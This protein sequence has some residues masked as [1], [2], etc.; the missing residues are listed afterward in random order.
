MNSIQI[1]AWHDIGQRDNYEDACAASTVSFPLVAGNKQVTEIVA[2]DGAGFPGNGKTASNTGSD[3]LSQSILASFAAAGSA[4][5]RHVFA[6]DNILGIL[7]SALNH[8]NEDVLHR[9]VA[10]PRLKGMATTAVCAII[11]DGVLYVGWVGDTSC[12]VCNCSR[13]RKVTH[14]HSEVQRLIDA[15]LINEKEAKYHPLRHTINRF[16]GQPA[17]FSPETT[18]CSL[19]DGDVVLL[20]T[21]GLTDVLADEQIADHIC[22]YREGRYDFRELPK[23][24]VQH[25]L[26]AGTTDNV[27]VL[28]CEYHADSTPFDRTLTGAYPAAAAEAIR[29]FHKELINV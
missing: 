4:N 23:R 6:P 13:V 12:F 24:L 9:I 25:A 2:L 11:V 5:E 28:C 15:G 18:T 29:N 8:A 7:T 1:A 17:N 26:E 3:S 21:D 27:T 14:D 20:A 22:E 16:L 19:L 10:N